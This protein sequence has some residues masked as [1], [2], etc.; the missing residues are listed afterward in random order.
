MAIFEAFKRALGFSGEDDDEVEGIDATVTPLS[1]RRELYSATARPDHK[2]EPSHDEPAPVDDTPQQPD[3][4]MRLRIFDRV[5]EIFNE[6]LPAFL[7]AA[8]DPEAQRRYIYDALDESMKRYLNT[9][10][11]NAQSRQHDAWMRERQRLEG[12]TRELRERIKEADE[13]SANYTKQHLSSDRQLRT[14]KDRIHDLEQQIANL[15][16]EKEQFQLENRSLVNKLRVCSVQVSDDDMDYATKLQEVSQKYEIAQAMINDLTVQASEA[17]AE[18]SERAEALLETQQ[19]LSK[20]KEQLAESLKPVEDP[21]VKEYADTID[22]LRKQITELQE[23]LQQSQAWR[24]KAE[25]EL[26]NTKVKLKEANEDLQALNNLEAAVT[27]FE[28]VKTAKDTQIRQLATDK[29]QL[30]MLV[31]SLKAEV[32]ALKRTIEANLDTQVKKEGELNKEIELLKEDLERHRAIHLDE[33]PEEPAPTPAPE[34]RKQRRKRKP[35]ITVID[36]SIDDTDWLVSTPDPG[37]GIIS[38]PDPEF[39]YQAPARK[40]TPTNDDQLSLW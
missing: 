32:A 29:N 22:D 27:K 8:V 34:A 33:I 23:Q 5:V 18:A 15:E 12:E 3:E 39:G 4:A 19:E 16:G 10:E 7:K 35:K 31:D 26:Q 11:R 1:A 14:L 30:T 2:I 38:E 36:D 17:K 21:R 24:V 37:K 20:I 9:L 6:S 25:D 13:K 28:E 40:P